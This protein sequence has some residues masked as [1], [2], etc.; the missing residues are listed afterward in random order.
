MFE[1]L[2]DL[3]AE[4]EKLEAELPGI[5]AA[6]DRRASRDAGR[7]HAE[8]KPVVEA[9]QQWRQASTDVADARELLGSESDAEMRDFLKA[10]MAEKEDRVTTLEAEL[11]AMTPG[12]YPG[13]HRGGSPDRADAMVW[14]LWAL[15]LAP[16]AEP[17][18]RV[19]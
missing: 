7:R 12:G 9:Y 1:Q 18:V 10:E 2:N 14:A 15:L 6:G 17:R 3:E 8:L 11:R 19:V 13:G 5:Y 4:L 16:R